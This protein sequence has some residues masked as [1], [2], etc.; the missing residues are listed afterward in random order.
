MYGAAGSTA[1]TAL[2][3]VENNSVSVENNVIEGN[4]RTSRQTNHRPGQQKITG[5]VTMEREISNA[6]YAAFKAAVKNGTFVA[7]KFIPVTSNA[8][9]VIDGDFMISNMKHEEPIDGWQKTS[10]DYAANHDTSRTVTIT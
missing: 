3:I 6:G 4:F 9:D 5:S 2:G 7:M 10:F 1:S 8:S